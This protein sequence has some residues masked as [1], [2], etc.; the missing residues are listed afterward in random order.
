MS[1]AVRQREYSLKELYERRQKHLSAIPDFWPT[2]LSH[3]PEEFTNMLA[4]QDG[5]IL[6]S[7]TSMNVERYQI[8][9]G[10]EGEPRSLRFTFTFDKNKNRFFE[11]S[12]VTKDFEFVSR[13]DGPSGLVSKPVNF[14][15]TKAAKKA[16]LNKLLDLSEQLWQAEQALVGNRE[17]GANVIAIE[18]KERESLWQ[19]EKLREE[20]EKE[21]DEP[22]EGSFLNWFGY[23]GAVAQGEKKE[24]NAD[25]EEEDLDEEE[26]DDGILD[27]EIFPAGEE[28]ANVLAED[29]WENVIDYFMQ[30]QAEEDLDMDMEG[31]SEDGDAPELVETVDFEGF[32]DDEKPPSKKQRML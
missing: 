11:D 10:A 16:G 26:D 2:V 23:R 22:E 17:K 8:K 9:N 24:A 31:E 29:L 21:E 12:T 32:N 30:A 27:V 25:A 28:V 7:I 3:G 13:D 14:K 1:R 19:Y 20:L 18:Q 5:E 6:D 15:W 4:P